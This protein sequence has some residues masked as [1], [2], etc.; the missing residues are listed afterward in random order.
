MKERFSEKSLEYCL[1]IKKS[2]DDAKQAYVCPDCFEQL[3]MA[4]DGYM[5]CLNVEC[6]NEDIWK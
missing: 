3:Y 2:E 6:D 4:D 1:K 5:L